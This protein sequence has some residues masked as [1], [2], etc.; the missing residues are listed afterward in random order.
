MNLV[1]VF[2]FVVVPENH[3]KTGVFLRKSHNSKR[4]EFSVRNCTRTLSLLYVK[5]NVFILI[6]K[7]DRFN[8][9]L[10]NLQTF[11]VIMLTY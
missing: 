11:S 5:Q 8:S 10:I 9:L 1:I 6:L 3:F 4:V 7:T 2:H